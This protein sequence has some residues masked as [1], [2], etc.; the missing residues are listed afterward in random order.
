MNS[1]LLSAPLVVLALVIM[2]G[3]AGCSLPTRGNA[4]EPYTWEIWGSN[5]SAWWRLSDPAG[6]AQAQ[7]EIGQPP[8][9]HPGTYVGEV[10]LG[11]GPP[12]VETEPWAKAATF[13]GSGS[14]EVTGMAPT[15]DFTVEAFVAPTG[16]VDL[17]QTVV[18][19]MGPAG[20]WALSVVGSLG[21]AGGPTLVGEVSDGAG[22]GGPIGPLPI[23]EESAS[24]VAMTHVAATTV[25]TLYVNG[26]EV[27]GESVGIQLVPNTVGPLQIGVNFH[28]WIQD[29]VFYNHVLTK[30]EI[31]G[32]Y[33][34]SLDT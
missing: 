23:S 9:D 27:A 25:I 14:V 11:Q 24:H 1:I 30:D 18:R 8:G 26:V 28:G 13:G 15:S 31:A 4:R 6:S 17:S 2:L 5:P 12:A 32:H 20:G 22:V 29:V 7:D 3:F 19:N 10:G 33:Q 21:P 34:A 16:L